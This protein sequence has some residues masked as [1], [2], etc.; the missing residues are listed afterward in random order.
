MPLT[1]YTFST[2]ALDSA[3]TVSASDEDRVPPG[4]FSLRHGFPQWSTRTRNKSTRS[5]LES[6]SDL[7]STTNEGTSID[8]SQEDSNDPLDTRGLTLRILEHLKRAL[9]DEVFLDDLPFAVV[10][11]PSAWHAWRAYRGL[12]KDQ[13][14]GRSPDRDAETP[15]PPASPK[16]MSDWN[17]DGV[18]ESR[19]QDSINASISEGGL[20]TNQGLVKF[21]KMDKVQLAEIR[22]QLRAS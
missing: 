6:A 9:E 12:A 14:R 18:W 21:S 17:W 2:G 19:V 1:Q 15:K 11:N 5:S 10:G 7:N 3:G 8:A 16:Q 22:Q 4:S 20:Y 13:A